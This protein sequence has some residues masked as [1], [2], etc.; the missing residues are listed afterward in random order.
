MPL[1]YDR[2]CRLWECKIDESEGAQHNPDND[3]LLATSLYGNKYYLQKSGMSLS[4][5]RHYTWFSKDL[6][7]GNVDEENRE[8]SISELADV[9][10][11][12]FNMDIDCKKPKTERWLYG[13][14]RCMTRTFVNCVDPEVDISTVQVVI[15]TTL[16]EEYN[17][18]PFAETYE[19][20]PCCKSEVLPDEKRVNWIVCRGCRSGWRCVPAANGRPEEKY[21]DYGAGVDADVE[22]PNPQP[23]EVTRRK[24]G[25]HIRFRNA[26]VSLEQAKKLM[27]AM[28]QEAMVYDKTISVEEWYD[29]IDQAPLHR[30]SEKAQICLRRIFTCKGDRCKM[31]RGRGQVVDYYDPRQTTKCPGCYGCGRVAIRDKRYQIFDI[32]YLCKMDPD[33]EVWDNETLRQ[34]AENQE[35]RLQQEKEWPGGV[36]PIDNKGNMSVA[37]AEKRDRDRRT[38]RKKLKA[39][40]RA[41]KRARGE[42]L[43]AEDYDSDDEDG[44]RAA[45]RGA[46]RDEQDA[47][48]DEFDGFDGAPKKSGSV[49]RAKSQQ[50]ILRAEARR[51]ARGMSGS[52]GGGGAG[53]LGALIDSDDDEVGDAYD[54]VGTGAKASHPRDYWWRVRVDDGEPLRPGQQPKF[55]VST[56]LDELKRIRPTDDRADYLYCLLLCSISYI[57]DRFA[58]RIQLKIPDYLPKD[59][60]EYGDAAMNPDSRKD[61]NVAM[62]TG[63]D[64]SKVTRNQYLQA[65]YTKKR[66]ALNDQMH[67][68]LMDIIVGTE[69]RY[70][71]A[72]I[73]KAY[74]EDDRKVLLRCYLDGPN[75]NF[76]INKCALHHGSRALAYISERHGVRIGCSSIKATFGCRKWKGTDW[77]PIDPQYRNAIFGVKN[78]PAHDDV[79]LLRLAEKYTHLQRRY[80][81]ESRR[82][83][84]SEHIKR[85]KQ[86]A[87]VLNLFNR[88]AKTKA[89]VV[90]T[91]ARFLRNMES[92]HEEFMR[93]S[94]TWLTFHRRRPG[95]VVSGEDGVGQAYAV[96]APVGNRTG[97]Y[98]PHQTIADAFDSD[99][100]AARNRVLPGHVRCRRRKARKI[101][102]MIW[103]PKEK[104]KKKEKKKTR[105]KTKTKKPQEVGVLPLSLEDEI[106]GV[107]AGKHGCD[108]GGE[109]ERSCC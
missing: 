49:S 26:I 107:A 3:V 41:S 84:L 42:K 76:C 22:N 82:K 104:K 29:I 19:Q 23:R 66:I 94:K 38:R 52:G 50:H 86:N 5:K 80:G 6:A 74:W 103:R 34:M 71:R 53:E 51:R 98:G 27:A 95:V 47:A 55:R 20:C 40:L 7:A 100:E 60:F 91:V 81:G 9:R 99:E 35:I 37:L 32:M 58:C 72:R 83:E 101:N 57:D 15:C 36:P 12:N 92:N 28:L 79:N 8:P 43:L 93:D 14:A 16:D 102:Y 75:S 88:C 90:H 63:R 77:R 70:A 89:V 59:V 13:F 46:V 109:D 31:C 54:W 10:A 67:S 39:K 45:A 87:D 48:D 11:F 21:I 105:E 96:T 108:N 1:V 62:L 65:R 25:I 4:H 73:D 69:K 64:A 97:V 44:V 17:M 56:P 30:R 68:L 2:N 24:N 106:A 18:V 33:V 85:I 61:R 78:D